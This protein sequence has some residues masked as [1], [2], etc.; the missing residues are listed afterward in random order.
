VSW[1]VLDGAD[2]HVL[3]LDDAVPHEDSWD[4]VCGPTDEYFPETGRHLYVHHSLD[5][6]EE[7]E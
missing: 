2:V 4:C 7:H 6:R 1:L 5:G 3:P